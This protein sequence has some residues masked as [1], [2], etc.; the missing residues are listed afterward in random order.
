M[1]DTP[2]ISLA[3]TAPFRLGTS[4]VRPATRE[5][6]G[7]GGRE[8]LEPRVMQVLVLLANHP[9]EVVTRDQMIDA[10]WDGRIVGNDAINRTI[11][12]IRRVA[13]TVGGG[14]FQVETV[15]KVGYR[16]TE[17]GAASAEDRSAPP[18][19][20]TA[21]QPD[22]RTVFSTL[23][24]GVAGAAGLAW[25]QWRRSDPV[26]ALRAEG[27]QDARAG[28]SEGTARG[29]ALVRE[30]AVRAPDD[31]ESWGALALARLHANYFN[32]GERARTQARAAQ[33]DAAQAD[34]RRALR[35]DSANISA[36]A[37]LA[38]ALPPFGNWLASENAL[39]AVLAQD[40]DQHEMCVWLSRMLAR[41]GRTHDALGA[42]DP[43]ERDIQHNASA[44]YW[45][46]YLMWAVGRTADGDRVIDRA[47]RLWPRAYQV[48]FSRFWTYAYSGRA[49]AALRMVADTSARPP[50]IPEWNFALIR[51]SAR[52][53]GSRLAP[54]VDA[55]QAAIVAAAQKG[56]GFGEIG[57]ELL[58]ELGRL[59]AAFDIA[60]RYFFMGD[61]VATRVRYSHEQG[62]YSDR[63][64]LNTRFLFTPPTANLR[65]DPRF[66][67]MVTY[68]GLDDYWQRSATQPDFRRRDLN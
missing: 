52:A 55:A 48:W 9:D 68:L 42:L 63:S 64:R 49:D 3:A 7:P 31:P 17:A 66:A 14:A 58:S 23:V 57:V 12:V 38:M 29:L 39:R 2:S 15:V 61:A 32:S 40:P 41:V 47:L 67:A 4:E 37:A 35:M 10:C 26:A 25:W 6:T 45:Q 46:S 28:T 43:V 27:L 33:A 56:T 53:L 8:I 62:A 18:V 19:G 21:W 16:L 65:A 34:A 51:F 50:G 44:L 1:S 59:D 24:A 22:R 11:G 60:R 13:E 54:D 20:L 30:A 36:Q 5:I